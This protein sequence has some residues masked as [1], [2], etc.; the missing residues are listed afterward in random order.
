MAQTQNGHIP[1]KFWE[2]A[3]KYN[4]SLSKKPQSSQFGNTESTATA[5]S[6][7][8]LS[9]CKQSSAKTKKA[10]KKKKEEEEKEK[11]KDNDDDNESSSYSAA[12]RPR[13]LFHHRKYLCDSSSDSDTNKKEQ[14]S[15][16]GQEKTLVNSN[17]SNRRTNSHEDMDG[18]IAAETTITTK[19]INNS[20]NNNNNNNSNGDNHSNDND[21]ETETESEHDFDRLFLFQSNKNT[22]SSFGEMSNKDEPGAS[23]PVK[24]PQQ[25]KQEQLGCSTYDSVPNHERWPLSQPTCPANEVVD[26][27]PTTYATTATKD[28][29]V[30]MPSDTTTLPKKMLSDA[31]S[32]NHALPLVPIDT[33]NDSS[34]SSL[35]HNMDTESNRFNMHVDSNTHADRNDTYNDGDDG[36]APGSTHDTVQSH[37]THMSGA[38]DD[39]ASLDGSRHRA[40]HDSKEKEQEEEE[41]VGS[42]A[43]SFDFSKRKA[44]AKRSYKKRVVCAENVQHKQFLKQRDQ[45]CVY[46][47]VSCVPLSLGEK[48]TRQNKSY[49]HEFARFF[50]F[51]FTLPL[52]KYTK[53]FFKTFNEFAFDNKFVLGDNIVIEW[54]NTLNKTA[55]TCQYIVKLFFFFFLEGKKTIFI[56][57]E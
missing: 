9:T 25:Q 18:V 35:E 51:F 46:L 20:N 17:K 45:V 52:K 56:W 43:P 48:K 39:H 57:L 23:Q 44:T 3:K 26:M 32:M 31:W 24:S 19:G 15:T 14:T 27:Q 5:T 36:D 55:G 42:S 2:M 37:D 34:S 16:L 40:R 28:S 13:K 22:A 41:H 30:T 8:I 47:F 53:Q 21:S 1:E 6:P 10:I 7:I 54:S 49:I 50:F 29:D 33:G 4:W 11:E 38:L 12:K